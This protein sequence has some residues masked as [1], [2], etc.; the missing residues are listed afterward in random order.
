MQN[1]L[2][3][4]EILCSDTTEAK[5][6][7]QEI[8]DWK[9]DEN[10]YPG[11]SVIRTGSE[12]TGGLMVKPPET[13]VHSLYVYFE[14]ESI[15]ATLKAVE[16]AGGTVLVSRTEIPGIGYWGMFSDP[17]GVVIGILEAK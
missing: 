16:S 10:S 8:F 13:P 7:Y 1:T 4:F 6:F 14:V 5:R 12:P 11:Y 17:D 9:F 15:D 3:H 2:S